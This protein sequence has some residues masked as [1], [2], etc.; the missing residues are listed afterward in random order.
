MST[1]MTKKSWTPVHDN[2]LAGLANKTWS[3]KKELL[4]TIAANITNVD[5]VKALYHAVTHNAI[6]YDFVQKSLSGNAL[7]LAQDLLRDGFDSKTVQ[8]QVS[9]THGILLSTQYYNALRFKTR[10]GEYN[11]IAHPTKAGQFVF[12]HRQKVETNLRVVQ[13]NAKTTKIQAQMAGNWVMHPDQKD[14][15]ANEYIDLYMCSPAEAYKIK[16][17]NFT[18]EALGLEFGQLIPYI[19]AEQLSTLTPQVILQGIFQ[20]SGLADEANSLFADDDEDDE[21]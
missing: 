10:R 1:R 15:T 19:D 4:E 21:A 16:M 8:K 7:S 17:I 11:I 12:E 2:I 13:P 5:P 9:L 6:K 20:S 3:N 14:V 18:A